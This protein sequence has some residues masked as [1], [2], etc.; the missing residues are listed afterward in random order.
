[1]AKEAKEACLNSL[2]VVDVEIDEIDHG[3]AHSII[4][5]FNVNEKK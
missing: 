1:L 3:D 5:T 4:G 2:L